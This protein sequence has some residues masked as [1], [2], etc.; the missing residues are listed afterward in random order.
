MT[1]ID[2]DGMTKDEVEAEVCKKREDFVRTVMRDTQEDRIPDL[3]HTLATED[4]ETINV[5]VMI[6]DLELLP[7]KNYTVTEK[8][9][10]RA[11]D[12][13]CSHNNQA[14]GQWRIPDSH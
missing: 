3:D 2:T 9:E 1:N 13:Y 4:E 7:E 10:T 6:V 5:E 14:F 11:W 12:S 8:E